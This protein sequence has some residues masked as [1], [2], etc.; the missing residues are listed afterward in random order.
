EVRFLRFSLQYYVP[1]FLG[2]SGNLTTDKNKIVA[3]VK[4]TT[5]ADLKMDKEVFK[6]IVKFMIESKKCNAQE[7]A[8]LKKALV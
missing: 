2:Y 6:N 3:L 7:V 1:A 8:I 5:A 4:N